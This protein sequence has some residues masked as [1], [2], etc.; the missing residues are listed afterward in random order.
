MA[1]K[2]QDHRI[3]VARAIRI[4][5]VGGEHGVEQGP[6]QV[7]TQFPEHVEVELEILSDLLDR[8]VLED[9][10]Q[11]P[12]EPLDGNV[13]RPLLPQ[14]DVVGDPRLPAEGNPDGT[15]P[16]RIEGVGLRVDGKRN[17]LAR[18]PAE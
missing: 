13:L 3:E 1:Q 14:W 18:E 2:L 11:D 16:P 8:L 12:T 10:A 5:E 7:E 9:R 17:A 4:E 6:P 15:G